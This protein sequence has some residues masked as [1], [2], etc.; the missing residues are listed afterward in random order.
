MRNIIPAKFSFEDVTTIPVS[1]ATAYVDLYNKKLHGLDLKWPTETANQGKY[2]G[3][4]SSCLVALALWDNS[5]SLAFRLLKRSATDF[6]TA[7][8]L[9]K[10]SGFS[11]IITTASLKHTEFW[12]NQYAISSTVTQQTRNDLLVPD[13][14]LITVLNLTI[15]KSSDVS[16]I[17]VSGIP[18]L[19]QN[20]ELLE[21][22]YSKLS[23][24]L[25]QGAIIP[26]RMYDTT[27]KALLLE[28]KQ[29]NFVVGSR[30]I[31]VP[32]SGQLLVKVLAA[33]L[34]PLDWKIQ[35]YGVLV[36]N[37]PAVLGSD[38]AGE[39]EAIGE[40]VTAF[41]KGDRVFAQGP[42]VS[43]FA[44]FQQYALT[45]AA[46]TAKIPAKTSFEDAA[47]IPVALTAAYVGLYN[48]KPHGLGLKWPTE[49]ANQGKYAGKP[50][51]VL[52]G[53]SSVGQL[54][55]GFSPIITT[56][57][58]KHTDFL[59]SLG[60]TNVL[61][62]NLSTDVLKAQVSELTRAPI[63]IV[64]DAI[65]SSVTQQAGNDLL[66]PGG[67]LIT[68][69]YLTITKSNDVNHIQVLGI[70]GLPQ[71]KELV[72]SLYAKLSLLLEQDAI[73][74]LGDGIDGVVGGLQKL[75]NDQVSGVKLVARP[76]EG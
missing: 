59:Q 63:D 15:T 55:S 16:R 27:Q 64:Y 23:L 25:E 10:L 62:R 9:T 35:K 28:S 11:P 56:A 40:G 13:G 44:G 61:D 38:I 43:D 72:E 65:S 1:L 32:G 46:T 74:V 30:S 8:Q 53:A 68:V 26:N 34:N 18:G 17:Q 39:V 21:P 57:S 2:A 37:Y 24:L 42:F 3:K 60:A 12:G 47:T 41:S 58:L 7:I 4:P 22:P 73:I 36:N 6:P 54:L 71:N 76:W 45:H 5:V 48:K 31:P 19:P 75:Q 70:L 67:H 52:G 51:I 66:V 14:H 49:I 20:N 69:V 29:G 33:G 50:I